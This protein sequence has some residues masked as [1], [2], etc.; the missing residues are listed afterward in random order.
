MVKESDTTVLFMNPPAGEKVTPRKT[1]Q[2]LSAEKQERITRIAVEEFS[3]KGF[4]GASINTMVNRMQIAKGSIFQ[5]FGDKK[6]LF[7]FVFNRS[8]ELVKDYLRSVRDQSADDAL[9]LR[10]AKTLSAGV[11]FI[12]RHPML[13]RLY[14]KVL[15]D[16]KVPFRDEILSSLRKHS[17]EYLKSLLENAKEK[18]ELKADIDT[19]K[20]AFVLDA[21]MDRF[22]SARAIRHLD[23]GLGIYQAG[24]GKT[25]IW[26]RDITE[27]I[28]RGIGAARETAQNTAKPL[29]LKDSSSWVL[30]LS[31]VYDE[32][33][34]L[35]QLLEHPC[36][37]TMGRR[38]IIS[39]K[40]GDVPVKLLVSGPGMIN[41]AQALTAAAEHEKPCLVIQTGCAGVFPQSGLDLGDVG[42]ASAE[43]DIQTGLESLSGNFFADDLPFDLINIPHPVKN[44]YP[45]NEELA[46]DALRILQSSPG[47]SGV[48]IKKGP[49]ITV[50]TI[51]T[52][53]ERANA[54]WHQF[55]PCMEQMEGAAAAHVALLYGIPFIE[56]RS[57]SNLVGK[58]DTQKWQKTPAFQNAC[59]SIYT[60]IQ[61]FEYKNIKY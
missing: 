34:D 33:S 29:P 21:V 32:V 56:I 17:T 38:Q 23:S 51:T 42:I 49:F 52:T 46:D 6:G 35:A 9:S 14:L 45:V 28:C 19:D 25:D 10:L 4:D 8:V 41:A 13:Y 47:L 11:H 37:A 24:P 55:Q 27:M 59:K 22:L 18:K 53:E 31:A 61:E 60:F 20:A 15:F 3:S 12:N 48:R 7:L 5:Y 44:K 43:I 54:L 30:I 2:N 36:R 40:I 1:F 39:G 50:S 58:R 16:P 57:A 26:I